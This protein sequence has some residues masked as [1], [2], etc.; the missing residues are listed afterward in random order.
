MHCDIH[1]TINL[2]HKSILKI[3]D[4]GIFFVIGKVV[5]GQCVPLLVSA[6]G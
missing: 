1:K 4:V 2:S 5:S 3:G 6:D